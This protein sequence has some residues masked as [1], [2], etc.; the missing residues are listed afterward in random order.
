MKHSLLTLALGICATTALAD[1]PIPNPLI[2]YNQFQRIVLASK[3]EREVRR[4]SEDAFISAMHEP[5]VVVL[6]AR[7][8]SRFRLRHVKGAVNLPFTE[9]TADT[10]ANVIP[11]K[12]STILIYCN[13]NFLNSPAAFA[14]KMPAASLNLSTYTSLKAYGYSNIF[15]LGPLLKIEQTKIP[16]AGSE[17][18]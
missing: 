2:N 1:E 16:F 13:N 15:E 14:T 11:D 6:D 18:D 3:G 4:L 17:V 9:F 10:L 7:T 5:G 8:E 12:Y